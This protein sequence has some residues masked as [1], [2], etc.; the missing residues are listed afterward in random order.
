MPAALAGLKLFAGRP[1][2]VS[3][4]LDFGHLDMHLSVQVDALSVI[5]VCKY[6]KYTHRDAL[7]TCYTF[8]TRSNSVNP[9]LR[10]REQKYAQIGY[11]YMY[12]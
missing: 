9:C 10:H 6:A 1:E 12:R 4:R 3:L 2:F 11:I 7:D 5:L 8:L